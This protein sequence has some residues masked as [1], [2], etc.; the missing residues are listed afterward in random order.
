MSGVFLL[1]DLAFFAANLLKMRD[2]GWLPLLFGAVVFTVMTTWRKGV[3]CGSQQAGGGQD[4]DQRFPG[5]A[6]AGGADRAGARHRGVSSA[7]SGT[8]VPTLLLHHVAQ[9]KALQE[10]VVT[11]TIGFDEVPRIPVAS[12]LYSRARLPVDSGT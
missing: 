12:A 9:F 8:A 6:C 3:G 7:R 2:G 11:L 10:T 4:T 1:V 5:A